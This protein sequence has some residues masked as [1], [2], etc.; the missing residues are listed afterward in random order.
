MSEHNIQVEVVYA[1]PEKQ[2]VVCLQLPPAS[3]LGAALSASGL[4]QKYPEIDLENGRFG[5]F[6]KLAKS[7]TPLRDRDRVEIYR[8]L[9]ADPR[10]I[11]Q[12]R[13]AEGKG[14]RKSPAGGASGEQEAVH[15]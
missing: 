10:Q 5:I 2:E 4:L 6:S 3:P 1:L 12:Q 11:R 9:I 14:L 15:L 7:D 13:A 8:P